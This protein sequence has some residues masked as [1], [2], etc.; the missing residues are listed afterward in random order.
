MKRQGHF[1]K[2]E[3]IS[4]KSS[5]LEDDFVFLTFSRLVVFYLLVFGLV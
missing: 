4:T 2:T 5:P 1:F 3:T